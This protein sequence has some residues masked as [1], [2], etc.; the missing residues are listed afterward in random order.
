VPV[1]IGCKF[2]SSSYWDARYSQSFSFQVQIG[3]GREV[4][5]GQRILVAGEFG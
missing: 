2:E 5:V 1:H 4:A 3:T